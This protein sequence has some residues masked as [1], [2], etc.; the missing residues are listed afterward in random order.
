VWKIL[1]GLRNWLQD[2][3]FVAAV[4][5]VVLREKR[6]ISTSIRS[7]KMLSRVIASSYCT[8]RLY[9]HEHCEEAKE[10][11]SGDSILLRC[12]TGLVAYGPSKDLRSEWESCDTLPLSYRPL[13]YRTL[14]HLFAWTSPRLIPLRP[15]YQLLA[16]RS[17]NF[18]NRTRYY[19]VSSAATRYESDAWVFSVCGCWSLHFLFGLTP[20]SVPC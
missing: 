17:C 10:T 5:A 9:Q 11:I 1:S 14:S 8:L 7:S 4:W 2:N 16:T 18:P 13:T 15:V 3:L 19:V 6:A 12:D 20:F